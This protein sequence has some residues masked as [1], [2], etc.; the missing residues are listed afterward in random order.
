MLFNGR[1]NKFF[2]HPNKGEC[3]LMEENLKQTISRMF[4]NKKFR[5]GLTVILFLIILISS[6]MIRIS[7][8]PLLVDKTTGQYG[9]ADPDAYY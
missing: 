7:N 2:M 9:L 8:L 3:Y 6:V 4:K 1:K 5:I